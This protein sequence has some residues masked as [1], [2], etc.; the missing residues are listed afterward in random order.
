MS[1][2]IFDLQRFDTQTISAG[3]TFA[4]DGV[5]YTAAEGDATLNLDDGKVSGLASGKVIATV[6]GAENSPAVTFDATDNAV[7]FTAT[8]DGEVIS[9]TPFPIEFIGGE[10]TYKGG[11]I[12]ITA[13]SDMAIVTQR[14]DF[15]LRN[16]N[17][18]ATDSAYIFTATSLTSESE[19]VIS[20]S[21][22]KPARLT[23]SN[24]ARL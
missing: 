14:G 3:E 4:A 18:F 9:I 19:H 13:G 6:T 10:F 5:T 15:I 20:K 7:T 21:A 2:F 12:D 23:W 1:N 8:S 17:H 16:E 24:S 11:R 22:P